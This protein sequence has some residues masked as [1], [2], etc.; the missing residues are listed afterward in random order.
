MS[1]AAQGL[2][3]VLG[4][5]EPDVSTKEF[6]DWYDGE[7]APARLTVPGITTAIRYKQV[8]GEKPEWLALYDLASPETTKSPAYLELRN[9]ASEI[10]KALIPRLPVLQ[11][12]IYSLIAQ[13]TKPNLPSAALPGKYLLMVLWSVPADLDAEFINGTRKST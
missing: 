4:Q 8:D 10:E 11:R 5:C 1:S 12:R 9:T 13:S 2:L 3:F 6:N 7:H